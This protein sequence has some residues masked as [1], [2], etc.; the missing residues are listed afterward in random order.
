MNLQV[1]INNKINSDNTSLR[2]PIQTAVRK[3][4]I[5]YYNWHAGELETET[6]LKKTYNCCIFWYGKC[7]FSTK[8]TL[9]ITMHFS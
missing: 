2:N 8:S 3:A 6:K 1:N 7:T 5:K 9:K 4:G